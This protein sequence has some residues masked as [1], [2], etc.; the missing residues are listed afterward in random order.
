MDHSPLHDE[1]KETHGNKTAWGFWETHGP[2]YS[3]S[4]VRWLEELVERSR[5]RPDLNLCAD[6]NEKGG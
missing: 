4:Y 5:R 2:T 6:D 1:F 3:S